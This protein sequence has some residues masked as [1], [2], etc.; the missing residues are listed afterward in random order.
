MEDT[1]D[2]NRLEFCKQVLTLL[3]D[4]NHGKQR[5]KFVFQLAYYASHSGGCIGVIW[6]VF[7]KASRLVE[8][9]RAEYGSLLAGFV[10][11]PDTNLGEWVKSQILG[12]VDLDE[13]VDFAP[14]DAYI[15][16][17][18]SNFPATLIDVMYWQDPD[19]AVDEVENISG[20]VGKEESKEIALAVNAVRQVDF[21]R[22]WGGISKPEIDDAVA[23][24]KKLAASP[25]WWVR[26]YVAE[27]VWRYGVFR[28][29]ELYDLMKRDPD[30]RVSSAATR[31]DAQWMKE[32]RA[33]WLW[34]AGLWP[35]L[36]SK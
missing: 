3:P 30:P 14:F 19:Q 18:Q 15:R 33:V 25:R 23:R 8:I 27:V 10:D 29:T 31:P 13:K 20:G 4:T 7:Y 12:G 21:L 2:S 16:H 6:R 36:G 28:R 1:V 32:E 24:L 26:R 9:D 34:G 17:H 35:V 22:S 5:T 11:S